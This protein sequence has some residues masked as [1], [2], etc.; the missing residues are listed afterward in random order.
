M[1]VNIVMEIR[2]DVRS[3]NSKIS[4][5]LKIQELFEMNVNPRDEMWEIKNQ[6]R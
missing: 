3:S 4:N 6:L 1:S 2:F 5:K